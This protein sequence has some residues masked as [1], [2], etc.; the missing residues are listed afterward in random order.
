MNITPIMDENGEVTNFV[1][2]YK[3]VTIQ[4]QLEQKLEN[5]ATTD[6][7][8]QV[9]NRYKINAEI[10][11]HIARSKRYGEPFSILM[12]DIDHFKQVNDTY[13]HYVGDVVLKDLSKIVKHNI[14]QVD[15]FGR[16]G[17]EEFILILENTQKESAIQIAEKIRDIISITTIADHYKITVSIGV[18]EYQQD[19]LKSALLQRVDTALYEAKENGRNQVRFK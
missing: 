8:T 10:D 14:R 19:E 1:A 13:G 6:S 17:G 15:S 11:K 5:L 3:D 16:W 2:T 18:S 7:L 4:M 9:N 12:L